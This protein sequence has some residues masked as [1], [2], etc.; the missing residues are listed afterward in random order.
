MNNSMY[1]QSLCCATMHVSMNRSSALYAPLVG[2]ILVGGFFLWSGIAEVLNLPFAISML[3]LAGIPQP[4]L[5]ATLAA[6]IMIGGG[7]ALVIDF[8]TRIFALLL[9]AYL[10]VSSLSLFNDLTPS[11]LQLFLQTMAIVGGL[12]YIASFNPNSNARS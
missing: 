10:L 4:A 1:A 2:R 12:L 11:H 5:L 3:T 9:I 8:K 7:T 6:A